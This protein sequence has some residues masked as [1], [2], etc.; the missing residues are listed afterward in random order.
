M[1]LPVPA[2]RLGHLVQQHHGRIGHIVGLRLGAE[3]K[4]RYEHWDHLRHLTPPDGLHIEEWWLGIKL[5]RN[6]LKKELPLHD[7]TGIPFSIALS[8]SI[9]RRLFLVA[10]D[11]AGALQGTDAMSSGTVRERYLIRSLMEE[12][13]TSSQLEGAST[14]TPIAKDMLRSGRP[15]RDHGERMIANNYAAM[16]E[17]MRWRDQPLTPTTIFEIHRLLTDGTLDNAD[18]AGRFRTEH[19]DIAVLD[20]ATG[21][22]LHVPPPAAELPARLQA[23]CDFANQGDDG[24]HF[25]H[26]VIRAI[27]IHFMIGYDHPFVDGNGRTARALFYW[28]MLR[29]GFWMTEYFSIS[30]ILRKAPSQYVRAYLHTES[31]EGDTTYFVDHQLDVLLKAIEG[32]RAYIARKQ[33]A[34]RDAETLLKPGSKLARQLNHRQRALLL[35]ALKHPEKTFTIAMH[36]QAHDIVYQTARADLL[37]LVKAKLMRQHKQ[38]KAHVF[39]ARPDLSEK[40]DVAP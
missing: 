32:V 10:R 22:V 30:S 3:V 1:K 6:A 8:D 33:R 4:R 16:R 11:A 29:A 37:G 7:K 31:D 5:A 20:H 36:R 12:A 19:E 39:V 38:G 18:D 23:L 35:N 28:S 17:L 34:Q 25:V 27:L 15:P 40:L 24:E 9:Q 14:T 13:M 26:P 21:T 2:L